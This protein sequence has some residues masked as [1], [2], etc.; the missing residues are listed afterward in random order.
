MIEYPKMVPNLCHCKCEEA[1]AR[2]PT[3]P[4]GNA[5]RLNKNT[6]QCIRK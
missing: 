1:K 3:I 6:L 4:C 5:S 2:N